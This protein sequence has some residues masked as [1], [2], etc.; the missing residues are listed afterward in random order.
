VVVLT[1]K[2]RK[3]ENPFFYLSERSGWHFAN[4]QS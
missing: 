2:K 3:K 4:G 1:W